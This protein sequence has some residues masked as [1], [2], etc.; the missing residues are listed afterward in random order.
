MH[1]LPRYALRWLQ[2]LDLLQSV[3]NP[4]RDL[5]NGFV[6]VEIASRY[7]PNDIT[8]QTVDPG[9]SIATRLD[10]WSQLLKCLQRNGISCLTQDMAND[11]IHYK[12]GAAVRAVIELYS[13]I[14]SRDKPKMIADRVAT[15]P[16]FAQATASF[17][18]K[19]AHINRIID[20]DERVQKT[21]DTLLDH[22]MKLKV[23]QGSVGSREM[24]RNRRRSTKLH[25]MPNDETGAS[26]EV[27]HIE[28]KAFNNP[29]APL[30]QSANIEVSQPT[31]SRD[32]RSFVELLTIESGGVVDRLDDYWFFEYLQAADSDVISIFLDKL[33]LS[34]SEACLILRSNPSEF[35]IVIVCLALCWKTHDDRRQNILS[36]IKLSLENSRSA[37]LVEYVCKFLHV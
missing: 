26:V 8:V 1:S 31:A 25:P 13:A 10:N 35:S 19:D 30:L 23:R 32:L 24:N 6:F 2:E 22:E 36:R 3:R 16:R 7:F 29:V 5:A 27:K 12:P 21:L 4:R 17:R 11:V 9:I 34:L 37:T 14:T 20:D 15:P 28:I 33:E 18:V